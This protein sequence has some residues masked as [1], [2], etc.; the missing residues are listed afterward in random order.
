MAAQLLQLGTLALFSHAATP[1]GPCL[2]AGPDLKLTVQVERLALRAV[3]G[4]SR[5]LRLSGLGDHPD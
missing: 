4:Q 1:L 2:T 5:A 3:Y